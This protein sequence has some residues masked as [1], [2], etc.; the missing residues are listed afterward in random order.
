MTK[1]R[2]THS[3]VSIKRTVLIELSDGSSII[4]SA[5]NL[6]IKGIGVMYP[7]PAE[8]GSRLTL[9]FKL[10]FNRNICKLS[11]R[12]LVRH[13]HLCGQ[14]YYIGFEF[15]DVDEQ[16]QAV[17]TAFIR[18]IEAKRVIQPAG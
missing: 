16:S 3:R 8:L 6:S 15:Q 13:S 12:G 14:E 10:P 7:A 18:D 2:R 5:T 9:H 11:L 1:E 4:A 17:L